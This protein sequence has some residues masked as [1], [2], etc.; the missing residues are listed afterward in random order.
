MA[1]L[2]SRLRISKI[3]RIIFL[4]GFFLM[5]IGR[6]AYSS[7][8]GFVQILGDNYN[9]TYRYN[10]SVNDG[11]RV[12]GEDGAV[13]DGRLLRVC[14][15][16]GSE[17]ASGPFNSYIYNNT[18]YV[19]ENISSGFTFGLSSEGILIANNIFC[20][21]GPTAALP[22]WPRTEG[23]HIDHVVFRNNLYKQANTIPQSLII[24]DSNPFYGNPDFVNPGGSEPEDYIPNNT[25]IIKNRGIAIPKLLGDHTGIAR[26]LR[27]NADILGNAVDGVPDMGAIEVN[28]K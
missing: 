8:F 18:I 5:F 2:T 4:L 20:I 23:N 7:S 14:G 1:K 28:N 26:G 12:K 25:S 27:V 15:Y 21:L 11:H 17:D 16:N 6:L 3:S 24:Q 19:D 13:S 10:I 9:C 22:C